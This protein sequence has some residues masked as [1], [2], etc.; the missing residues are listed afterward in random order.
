MIQNPPANTP[1]VSPYVL[2]EDVAAALEWLTAAFGFAERERIEMP[3]GSIGHA[4][5]TIG[6]GVIM[7]G[8]PG[9]E[10][11]NPKR[12][13]ATTQQIY[14]YVDDVDA[15]YAQAKAA[16]AEVI[17]EPKD[18]FYGDRRYGALDP[19]GH[20]WYFATHVRDVPAEEMKPQ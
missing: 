5:M 8:C 12:L 14:V 6:E 9:P 19:E 13:G 17:E 10:Y 11:K 7:M 15:H 1:R 3:D 4:E 16:G 20:A 18:Q 2:Y